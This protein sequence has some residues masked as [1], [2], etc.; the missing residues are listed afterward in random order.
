MDISTF[1]PGEK[2]RVYDYVENCM[3]EMKIIGLPYI[4]EDGEIEAKAKP[5]SHLINYLNK[6]SLVQ[7][8]E[9]LQYWKTN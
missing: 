3:V 4:N 7:Y 2:I 9:S 8:D 1:K 5:H 6:K